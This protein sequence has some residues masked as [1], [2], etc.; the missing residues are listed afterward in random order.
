MI[1]EDPS[2]V[3]P[4]AQI[5]DEFV[6]AYRQG[7]RPSVEDLARRYP[8]HADDIRQLLP[9]LVMMEKAKSA[10]TPGDRLPLSAAAAPSQQLGDYQIVREVGRGATRRVPATFAAVEKKLAGA[11]NVRPAFPCKGVWASG[12]RSLTDSPPPCSG[13]RSTGKPTMDRLRHRLQQQQHQVR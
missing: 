4:F 2:S 11:V 7:K 1:D 8:E 3:G 5:A 10:D 9:A 12:R 6:E 13:R